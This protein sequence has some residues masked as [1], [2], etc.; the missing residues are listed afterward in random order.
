M[1]WH[2]T[3]CSFTGSAVQDVIKHFAQRWEKVIYKEVDKI[4]K[5]AYDH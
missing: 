2:D 1:P 5:T 4:A 3:A